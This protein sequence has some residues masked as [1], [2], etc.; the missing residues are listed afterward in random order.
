MGGFNFPLVTEPAV[1]KPPNLADQH[2][3]VLEAKNPHPPL[4][5]GG[6]YTEAEIQEQLSNDLD[7]LFPE[8]FG[9]DRDADPPP[10]DAVATRKGESSSDSRAALLDDVPFSVK[11]KLKPK[12]A[13]PASHP[14]YGYVWSGG[15]LVKKDK[16]QPPRRH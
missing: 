1:D 15:C 11:E 14:P 9:P 6:G 12:P 2:H 13:T 4:E 5:E 10:E 3:N 8:L 7:E 16:S